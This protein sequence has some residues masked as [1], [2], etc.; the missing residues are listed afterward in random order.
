MVWFLFLIVFCVVLVLPF[1]DCF[2]IFCVFCVL[3]FFTIPS[4]ETTTGPQN[5]NKTVRSLTQSSATGSAVSMTM[6]TND[7][8]D[9]FVKSLRASNTRT[10]LSFSPTYASEMTGN[11]TNEC[12]LSYQF[13]DKSITNNVKTC[14]GYNFRSSKNNNV[15]ESGGIAFEKNSEKSNARIQC[16]A[17]PTTL[18][19]AAT[20]VNT[21]MNSN[22]ENLETP[23]QFLRSKIFESIGTN[24]TLAAPRQDGGDEKQGFVSS[25]NNN[26]SDN[27]GNRLR[28]FNFNENL[29]D[30][31]DKQSARGNRIRN[32][33][34]TPGIAM[35]NRNEKVE[36]RK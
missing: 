14:H 12:S 22:G 10:G 29:I 5:N 36:T 7:N 8:Y 11:K 18:T 1:E 2:L 4:A 28:T 13:A 3:L 15:N 33:P 24:G 20:I 27:Y 23:R 16:L 19:T 6:T 17:T 25:F 35:K 26:Q 34:P 32:R 31:N 30:D 21:T 9:P